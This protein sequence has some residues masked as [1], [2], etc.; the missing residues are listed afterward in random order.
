MLHQDIVDLHIQSKTEYIT[1]LYREIETELIYAIVEML[2]NKGY[3][4]TAELKLKK[5]TE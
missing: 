4:A 2:V 5:L 3:T 1:L